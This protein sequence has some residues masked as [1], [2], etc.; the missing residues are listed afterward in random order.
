MSDDYRRR[1][2]ESYQ[3][4]SHGEA[5]F[6]ELAARTDEPDH[7]FKWRAL[8]QL[9][10]ETKERLRPLVES[11]GGDVEEDPE[12]AVRGRADAIEWAAKGFDE[13]VRWLDPLLPKYVR[14]FEKLEAMAPEGDRAL[15]ARVTAHEL[16]IQEFTTRELQ[17]RA[18]ESIAPVVDLLE[19]PPARA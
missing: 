16:A 19:H 18:D 11:L 15:L 14:F 4:E 13:T 5:L 10:A 7:R 1:V 2:F 3:G 6:R 9:E 12:H 8:E 17:G